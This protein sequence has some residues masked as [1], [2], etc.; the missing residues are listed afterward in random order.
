MPPEQFE[1]KA[2]DGRTDIY[3]LGVT[4]YYLLT[5]KR[6]HTG[7]G[8]AQILLSVMTKEPKSVCE[9]GCGALA[10]RCDGSETRFLPPAL[11]EDVWKRSEKPAGAGPAGSRG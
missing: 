3:A 7:N 2:K 1:G 5:L 6:P 8:P 11:A 9:V 10:R 4:F